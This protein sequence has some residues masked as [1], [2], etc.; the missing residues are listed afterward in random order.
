MLSARGP[1]TVRGGGYSYA[2]AS[3]GTDTLH[4]DMRAWR[5]VT[6]FDRA[7]GVLD[8][9]AGVSLGEVHRLTTPAGWHVPSQPGYPEITIGGCIAGDVHGKNQHLAGNFR[10]CVRAIRLW[11]PDHGVQRLAPGD[12][13]FELTMGGLG[14][15]GVI[16]GA[17]LQL[18]RLVSPVVVVTTT[19]I[20]DA[21]ATPGALMTGPASLF[22]YTWQ[23]FTC[24]TRT[25]RGVAY[26][27]R[28]DETAV[29]PGRA[30]ER[31]TA[32]DPQHRGWPVRVM[33]RPTIVALNAGLELGL[34]LGSTSRS[35]GLMDF[36]FPAARRATYFKMF[37]KAGF[38][39]TQVLVPHR[40]AVDFLGA[41]AELARSRRAPVALASCKLFSGESRFVR[42]DGEGIVVAV[43]A[44]RDQRGT[45]FIG[46]VHRLMLEHGGRPNIL[47]DSLL[48]AEIV[49]ASVDGVDDFRAGL[50]RVDPARRFQSVL[51][52]RLGL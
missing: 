34:R 29:H 46:A 14:L 26:S 20:A 48:S 27:A 33:Y 41:L 18:D 37:G 50:R 39:E 30:D 32:L 1:F 44:P 16:L 25:G 43:D 21:A 23:N 22:S 47:K 2:P 17:V 45:E 51:A 12:E 42:F 8:V 24:R 28:Y 38:H 13:L 49:E 11:H 9:E 52:D 31:Y 5:G 36:L 15:T 7:A 19:P 40:R 3:L 35:V 4:L 6:D 10:H